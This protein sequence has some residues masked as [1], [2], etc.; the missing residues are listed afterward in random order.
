MFVES[1]NRIQI[2]APA[3]VPAIIR[4]ALSFFTKFFSLFMWSD[5]VFSKRYKNATV[6]IMK[7]SIHPRIVVSGIISSGMMR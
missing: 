2:K 4:T 7:S 6:I 1:G 5:N 3:I